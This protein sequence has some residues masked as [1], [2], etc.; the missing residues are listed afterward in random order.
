MS[1]II[2]DSQEVFKFYTSVCGKCKHFYESGFICIAFPDGIPTEILNAT[3]DHSKPL[4][5]QK[6]EIVFS[7]KNKQHGRK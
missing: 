6:N 7:K 3:N 1:S 4:P 5:E 2:N